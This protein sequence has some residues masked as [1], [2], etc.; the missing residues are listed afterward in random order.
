MSEKRVVKVH[1]LGLFDYIQSL[2]KS[3]VF[4]SVTEDFS[5]RSEI[6][7][8]GTEYVQDVNAPRQILPLR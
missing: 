4:R 3:V 6:D 7:I 5:N 1:P 2:E 8:D